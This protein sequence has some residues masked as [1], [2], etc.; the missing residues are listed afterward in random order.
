MRYVWNGGY[1]ITWEVYTPRMIIIKVG[2]TSRR[3]KFLARENRR[4]WMKGKNARRFWKMDAD[5]FNVVFN[6]EYLTTIKRRGES[7]LVTVPGYQPWKEN[8]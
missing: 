3:N 4:N 6:Y 7:I 5:L 2:N 8:V 1:T